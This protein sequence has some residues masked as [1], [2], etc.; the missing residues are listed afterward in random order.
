MAMFVARERR[1]SRAETPPV[2]PAGFEALAEALNHG[3]AVDDAHRVN[4]V[5]GVVR[6]IGRDAGLQGQSIDDLMDGLAATYRRGTVSQAPPFDV[7]RRLTSAWADTS[8]SYLHA[9][10]C[11]DPLTGLASR[12]HVRSRIAEIYRA[13]AS[14]GLRDSP[15]YALVVVEIAWG[16]SCRA[17]FDR[18]MRM[19][20]IAELLR[21]VYQGDETIGQ[22]SASRVVVVV[23]RGDSVSGAVAVVLDLVREWEQRAGLTTRVWVEGFPGS[24]SAADTMLD[25][26]AR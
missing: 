15:P 24:A 9:T 8:L 22:L 25:E 6:Q 5:N 11:E 26:L 14:R 2:V 20:D 1:R 10:S 7:V 17:N 21:S 13:A 12:A 16:P 3:G 19:I 18:M 4:H 23:R